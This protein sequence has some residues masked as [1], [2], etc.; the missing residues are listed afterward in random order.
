MVESAPEEVRV[1]VLQALNPELAAALHEAE[2]DAARC[3]EV[4]NGLSTVAALE[5]V[6][7]LRSPAAISAAMG[8]KR[9][10]VAREAA[11]R[12]S[13]L[14]VRSQTGVKLT[15][16][17]IAA[18]DPVAALSKL[19]EV[20]AATLEE[21]IDADQPT[22]LRVLHEVLPG[23]TKGGA[24]NGFVGVMLAKDLPLGGHVRPASLI[25]ALEQYDGPVTDAVVDTVEHGLDAGWLRETL[26]SATFRGATE[27][28][29]RALSKASL[30][31]R[32]VLGDVTADELRAEVGVSVGRSARLRGVSAGGA[33]TLHDVLLCVRDKELLPAAVE[34]LLEVEPIEDREALAA[35]WLGRGDLDEEVRA[36]VV[37]QLGE[38]F[39]AELREG[40]LSKQ[41]VAMFIDDLARRG[42]EDGA[43]A[44]TRVLFE[45]TH[46]G[47]PLER[48]VFGECLDRVPGAAL[49]MVKHAGVGAVWMSEMVFERIFSKLGANQPAWRVVLSQLPSWDGVLDELVDAAARAVE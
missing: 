45:L 31:A 7:H 3:V 20:D 6:G 2:A 5:L 4:L 16:Q 29:V 32:L 42:R 46:L 11:K 36:A 48:E 34:L 35:M 18:S 40:R 19:G 37:L 15:R 38:Q 12:A 30:R 26:H 47:N 22:A 14:G 8:A 10:D 41:E 9:S 27:S 28:G 25:R 21:W 17:A 23:I 24:L 33:T 1:V 44:V 13:K 43:A 49:T 39:A